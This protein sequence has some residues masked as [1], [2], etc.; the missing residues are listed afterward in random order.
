MATPF[1]GQLVKIQGFSAVG[2]GR[3]GNRLEPAPVLRFHRQRP[4]FPLHTRAELNVIPYDLD[5]AP[6]E[7]PSRTCGPAAGPLRMGRAL[8]QRVVPQG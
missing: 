3:N 2:A 7:I 8:R 1:I 5:L 6:V 4:R